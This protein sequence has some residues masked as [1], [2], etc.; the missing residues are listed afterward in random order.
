MH[1]CTE[2][3]IEARFSSYTE[4]DK[5][6]LLTMQCLDDPSSIAG[7]Y[8]EFNSDSEW[9]SLLLMVKLCTDLEHCKSPEDIDEWLEEKSLVFAYDQ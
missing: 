4:A 7:L 3:D 9:S 1:R 5:A 6:E 2:G 8:G